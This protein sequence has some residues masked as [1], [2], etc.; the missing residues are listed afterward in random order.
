MNIK[1]VGVT[2]LS[3]A[4][5]FGCTAEGDKESR[6]GTQGNN[7]DESAHNQQNYDAQRDGFNQVDYDNGPYNGQ[8]NNGQDY[9][10]ENVGNED[11][12]KDDRDN[13]RR[14]SVAD[15]VADKITADID[16]VKRAYVLKTD[17]DA[18]VAVVKKGESTQ[19]LNDDL[20]KEI[21]KAAKAADKDINN[22]FVS[23]NPDFFDMTGDYVRDV[24]NGDPVR[25]FFKE[26]GQM[27]DRIF[28]EAN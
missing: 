14:Y 21:S 7:Y 20:K 6:M 2:I 3:A 13:N 1:L 10:E 27:V 19:E 18:Y 22:V 11:T 16:E 17:R 24:Q 4:V 8:M 5:L 26:F 25:G 12:Y 15:K 28:P 23:S 9:G